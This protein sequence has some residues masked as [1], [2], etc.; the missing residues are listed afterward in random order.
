[1]IKN[2]KIPSLM[3]VETF[4]YCNEECKFCPYTKL[5]R[6]KGSMSFELFN[7]LVDEHSLTCEDAKILFPA[8]VGEPLLDNRIFDFVKIAAQNY[9]NVAMFSNASLLYKN[10][11]EKLIK[12]GLTEIMLTLHGLT[13]EAYTNITNYNGYYSVKRN[14]VDFIE[15]N[16]AYGYPV[17]VY[18]DIYT[19][20][21]KED[22]DS[23]ELVNK[24]RNHNINLFI[25]P[26]ED[27]HNWG[28]SVGKNEIIRNYGCK[29]IY[30][31]FAVLFDGTIVP[32]V[33]DY[34]AS[35]ILGDANKNSLDE[36][37]N[38]EEYAKLVNCEKENTLCDIKLCEHCNIKDI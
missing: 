38:G 35:Y 29:R 31:Q 17:N 13:E 2:N 33:I 19:E 22:I 36:I 3:R 21:S 11:A 14:I 34:D 15:T 18:L 7:R 12:S 5:T 28:G 25:K 4:T 27:T 9:K 16:A 37:F 24:A 20:A 30:N 32:C 10:N 6:K 1:M 26:I 23:D 8:T